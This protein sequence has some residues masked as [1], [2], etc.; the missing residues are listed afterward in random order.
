MTCRTPII[1]PYM[2]LKKIVENLVF[3]ENCKLQN[4][5]CRIILYIFLIEEGAADFIVFD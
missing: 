4:E 3:P 5:G 2:R 1:R